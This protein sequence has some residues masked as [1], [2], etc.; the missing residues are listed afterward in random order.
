MLYFYSVIYLQCIAY[1]RKI[2]PILLLFRFVSVGFLFVLVQSKH[3][4]SLFRVRSETT[5]TN[6]LFRIVPKLVSVP[7]LVVFESNYSSFEGH[8]NLNHTAHV[9]HI[10]HVA[11]MDINIARWLWSLPIS[12]NAVIVAAISNL[13]YQTFFIK[14]KTYG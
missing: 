14:H 8:P 2:R 10:G 5:E 9:H 3:R 1:F 12:R 7:V 11:E 4:N 6:V 13:D